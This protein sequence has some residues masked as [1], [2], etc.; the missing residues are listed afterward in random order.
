LA[1]L[2]YGWLPIEKHHKN[3]KPKQG[4]IL[5]ELVRTLATLAIIKLYVE[6]LKISNLF[7]KRTKFCQGK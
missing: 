4:P 7:F 1:K 5:Y 6:M 2:S 3:E